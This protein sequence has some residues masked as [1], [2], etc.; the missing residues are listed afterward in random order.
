M[1]TETEGF[2]VW[3]HVPALWLYVVSGFTFLSLIIGIVAIAL[4][5][6]AVTKSDDNKTTLDTLEAQMN[7]VQSSPV[8]PPQV[9]QE[10]PSVQLQQSQTER[11]AV[12]TDVSQQTT[13]VRSTPGKNFS[14]NKGP[15]NP[16]QERVFSVVVHGLDTDTFWYTLQQ[17]IVDAADFFRC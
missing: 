8:A 10:Q 12:A 2:K 11:A 16:F 9:T 4:G 14:D 6:A 1:E 3:R 5:A 15:D 17:G 13:N 7:V